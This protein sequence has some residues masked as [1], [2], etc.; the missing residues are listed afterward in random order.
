M[1]LYPS[2]VCAL[3]S[4]VTFLTLAQLN[5]NPRSPFIQLLNQLSPLCIY[6]VVSSMLDFKPVLWC[7][8]SCSEESVVAKFNMFI[9]YF[10]ILVINGNTEQH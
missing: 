4:S 5:G 6:F 2:M 1:F 7:D 9:F 10:V 3:L 8:F